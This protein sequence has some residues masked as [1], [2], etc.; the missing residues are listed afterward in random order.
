M[1]TGPVLFK[2]V[3]GHENQDNAG[4]DGQNQTGGRCGYGAFGGLNAFGIR[5]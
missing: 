1:S 4:E 3:N 2:P 5:Q